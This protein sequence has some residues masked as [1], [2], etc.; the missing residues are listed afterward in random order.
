M[1]TVGAVEIQ[2]RLEIAVQRVEPGVPTRVPYAFEE[3][4]LLPRGARLT[5]VADG[6]Y[7]STYLRLEDGL[8]PVPVVERGTRSAA[9]SS[10]TLEPTAIEGLLVPGERL[11]PMTFAYTQANRRLQLN[12]LFDPCENPADRSECMGLS[13]SQLRFVQVSAAREVQYDLKLGV[14]RLGDGPARHPGIR[15]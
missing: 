14:E 10:L 5:L 15:E 8:I 11:R 3:V 4:T 9:A 12:V 1:L 2:G 6:A 7:Q 13:T